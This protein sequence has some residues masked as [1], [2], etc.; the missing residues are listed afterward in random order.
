MAQGSPKSMPYTVG[1]LI[2]VLGAATALFS[3]T[4]VILSPQ[5]HNTSGDHAFSSVASNLWNNLPLHI[6]LEDNFERFTSLLNPN[7][8]E[9]PVTAHVDPHPFYRLSRYQF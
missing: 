8:T 7:T 9:L 1:G 2:R 5:K 6:R 3:S 4:L